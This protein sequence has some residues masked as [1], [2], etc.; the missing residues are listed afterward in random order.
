M[1]CRQKGTDRGNSALAV[2]ILQDLTSEDTES[3]EGVVEK[4]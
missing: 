4:D 3:T 2:V 1:F